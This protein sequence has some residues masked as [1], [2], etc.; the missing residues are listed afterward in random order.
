M[1]DKFSYFWLNLS[2]EKGKAVER[3]RR[4]TIGPNPVLSG[5]QPVTE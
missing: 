3:Q 5:R 2:N 4:K 1:F